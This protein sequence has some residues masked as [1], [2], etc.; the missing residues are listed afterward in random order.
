[1]TDNLSTGRIGEEMA[2]EYLSDKGYSIVEKNYRAGRGE[3][4]LIAR[5]D[6]LLVFIEV[7]RRSR[8]K[9]GFPEEAVSAAKEDIILRTAERYL[10]EINWTGE[11]RFDIIAISGKKI[12]HFTDAIA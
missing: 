2:A 12:E 11:I 6:N 3:I 9:F 7:K 10:E 5:L 4:D 8:E 1:M